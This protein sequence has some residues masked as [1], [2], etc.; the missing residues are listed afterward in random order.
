MAKSKRGGNPQKRLD[1]VWAASN[2]ER[3]ALRLRH[4]GQAASAVEMYEQALKIRKIEI[5][6]T[7]YGVLDEL[8]KTYMSL[9]RFDEAA[10]YFADAVA[11][12]GKDY[13]AQHPLL[14]PILEDWSYCS[15]QQ[16]DLPQ[17]EELCKRALEIRQKSML[18]Q[19]VHT[20]E[21]MRSLA[22]I[23]RRQGKYTEAEALLKQA[24]K[25][26]ETS[27]IGPEEE[28]L[29]EL[30]LLNQDQGKYAEAEQYFDQALHRFAQRAG[31]AA[32][33]A[34]CLQSYAALLRATD[35]GAMADKLAQQAKAILDDNNRRILSHSSQNEPGSLL[36]TEGIYA[37]SILH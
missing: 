12:I 17:A 34:T 30:A 27:T 1:P 35:R 25:Y 7:E 2:L 23:M 6:G 31:K 37:A 32:R 33:F 16:N 22:E 19:D 4:H 8:G 11:L 26:L 21:T 20:L 18:P 24:L 13:Y 36:F 28:F 9:N 5:P 10:T 15:C 14:A 3:L 29:Y